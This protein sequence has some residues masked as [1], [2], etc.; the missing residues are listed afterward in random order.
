MAALAIAIVVLIVAILPAE[1]GI[2]PT[3]IGHAFGF[4]KLANNDADATQNATTNATTLYKYRLTWPTRSTEGEP[5]D[6]Y[7]GEGGTDN[8]FVDLA[9][10]NV[11]RVEATLTW[12][13]NNETGG[14]RTRPDLFEIQ[15]VGPDGRV[16]E[17]DLGRNG[18]DGRG[19]VTADLVWRT[20]PLAQE[21]R[22]STDEEA[23][24]Q[25][26][27]LTPFDRSAIG[28]WTV[29]VT[30]H[31]AGDVD[32]Q[33]LPFSSPAGDE[34][35]EWMLTLTIESFRFDREGLNASKER[36]D[37]V[38]IEVPAGTGLEYKFDM[39]EGA[40]MEYSWTTTGPRLY[41][42]FHGEPR[43][44]TSGASTSHKSGSADRDAGSFT[45]PFAGMH[46]WYW[47]N[48]GTQGVTVELVTTGVYKVIGKK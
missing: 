4:T 1:Y 2:D 43:S 5:R 10:Q 21:V 30:L 34:G 23:A 13:D 20:A 28:E 45:A 32:T 9:L 44:D 7:T 33:G 38:R 22:A 42:D 14:Q 25:A 36:E 39:E 27:S 12:N 31:E 46:G 11:T 47:E 29:K 35:N 41:Y 6:G 18:D 40:S 26:A 19:N 16:G 24:E 8:V 3:G 17:P 37:R 15:V 48:Q